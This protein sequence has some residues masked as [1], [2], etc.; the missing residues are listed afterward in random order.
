M[1]NLVYIVFI[2]V[3][4]PLFYIL[5]V[6]QKGSRKYIGYMIVGIYVCLV[7]SEINGNIL[8]FLD[9]DIVYLSTTFTPVIEEVLKAVPVLIYAIYFSDDLQTVLGL[10]FSVGIGFAIMENLVMLTQNLNEVGYFWALIRVIGAA[11]LHGVC[12]SFVGFGLAYIHKKRKM[13]LPGTVALLAMAIS[14]HTLFN[15]LVLSEYKYI[16]F[17]LPL[18]FYI[19]LYHSVK[20]QEKKKNE[21][22]EKSATH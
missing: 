9:N 5:L 8:D 4:V 2:C 13:F 17:S 14:I 16:G 19:P 18:L 1:D 21:N 6:L 15:C 22:Q 10:A 20:N 12:T 3:S 7:S 11:L